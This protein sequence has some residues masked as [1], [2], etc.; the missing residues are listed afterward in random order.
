[1]DI[2]E[3][4]DMATRDI[5]LF[6]LN[7]PKKIKVLKVFEVENEKGKKKFLKIVTNGK[8]KTWRY[9]DKRKV[10]KNDILVRVVMDIFETKLIVSYLDEDNTNKTIKETVFPIDK[11][12]RKDL[13]GVT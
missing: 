5:R 10:T 2:L 6:D 9:G 11:I 12:T 8:Y 4:L 3:K 7:D 13:Q 1:M